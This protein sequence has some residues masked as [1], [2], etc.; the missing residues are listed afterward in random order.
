MGIKDRFLKAECSVLAATVMLSPLMLCGCNEKPEPT[1]T[2]T[3]ITEP[4]ATLRVLCLI[5]RLKL[6]L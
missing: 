3:E 2:E 6:R 1:E 4:S 5:R